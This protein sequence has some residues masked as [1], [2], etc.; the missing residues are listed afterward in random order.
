LILL[1]D[2]SPLGPYRYSMRRFRQLLQQL[3]GDEVKAVSFAQLAY[4]KGAQE[5]LE[6]KALVLGGFG[7][8]IPRRHYRLVYRPELRLIHRLQ[9]PTLGICG[10]HQ[11]LAVA[12]GGEVEGLGRRVRG[13]KPI[14]ILER[15]PVLEGLPDTVLVR[16]H[17]HDHVS[18][19]PEG[20]KL[21]ASSSTTKVEAMKKID[22]PLYGLQFHPER[23]DKAHPH[24]SIIL[25]NF[26]RVANA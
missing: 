4:R 25:S 8:W 3:S 7:G 24:G 15:D 13:F 21:L 22:A 16:Q 19:L 9:K 2:N 18:R 11:L 10:G 6:A 5:A 20:F 26:L 12:F 23:Y 14:E 17:H 1:V